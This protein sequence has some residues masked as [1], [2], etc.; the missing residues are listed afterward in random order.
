MKGYIYILRDPTAKGIFKI[1]MTGGTPAKRL[2]QLNSTGRAYDLELAYSCRVRNMNKAEAELHSQFAAQRVRNDR[3][4]FK[5]PLARLIKAAKVYDLDASTPV[6]R[7]ASREAN[8]N[9]KRMRAEGVARR[10][11]DAERARQRDIAEAEQPAPV[12]PA[13]RGI[14][15][16]LFNAV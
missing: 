12:E 1:G 8:R 13:P 4:F 15:H 3:E 16:W 6:D 14:L 2:A 9:A 11:A 10:K 7:E 5:A